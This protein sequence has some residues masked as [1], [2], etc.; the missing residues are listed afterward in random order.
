MYVNTVILENNSKKEN[1]MSILTHH[2]NNIVIYSFLVIILFIFGCSTTRTYTRIWYE[3]DT[4]TPRTQI[5]ENITITVDYVEK[6]LEKLSK[7]PMFSV[8]RKSLPTESDS[9]GAII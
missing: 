6:S 4:N 5:K 7:Y 9:W 1:E 8:T 3:M 2:I